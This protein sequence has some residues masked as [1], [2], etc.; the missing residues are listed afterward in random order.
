MI[1]VKYKTAIDLSFLHRHR[2]R[3]F[4][5]NS[6]G[7][8]FFLILFVVSCFASIASPAD[9][10]VNP[11]DYEFSMNGT[12]RVMKSNN[13]F[14]NEPNTMIGVFVGGETRGVVNSDDIIFVGNDVYF[15]VTMY[16]NEQEGELMD[17][18]VYVSSLDSIF[19]ADE[20]AIFNRVLTLGSPADPFILNIGMCDDILILGS[21]LSPLSGIYKAGLE[22]KFQGIIDVP[23]GMS[24]TLNAPLVRS[25]NMLNLEESTTLIIRGIGCN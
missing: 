14:L 24:L 21:D 19:T 5:Q 20:T 15:P 4:S 9:W 13:V 17:F 22:I 10:N 16:S 8:L 23:T 1:G 11:A 18:K 25:E 2:F 6:I 12:I 3:I 7:K